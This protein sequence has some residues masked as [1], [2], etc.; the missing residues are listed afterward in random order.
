MI[1]R[2]LDCV[3]LNSQRGFPTSARQ[4]ECPMMKAINQDWSF[5]GRRKPFRSAG[6]RSP[7]QGRCLQ[8][9]RDPNMNLSNP[10]GFSRTFSEGEQ[11]D[12][13]SDRT[14]ATSP[15][16]TLEFRPKLMKYNSSARFMYTLGSLGPSSKSSKFH[17]LMHRIFDDVP[18]FE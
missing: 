10:W 12:Y 16:V 7:P 2:M 5:G 8:N 17:G 15:D 4:T 1:D 13:L 14:I 9:R 11:G 3:N 18:A 6:L